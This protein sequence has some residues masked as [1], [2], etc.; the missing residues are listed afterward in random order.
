MSD[1]N[2]NITKKEMQTAGKTLAIEQA[3]AGFIDPIEE[4]A[5]I[6]IFKNNGRRIRKRNAGLC[7]E[8]H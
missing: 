2:V 4:V 5:K 8:G 1:V 3:E 6:Q 7:T